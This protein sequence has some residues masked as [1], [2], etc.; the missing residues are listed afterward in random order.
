[1]MQAGNTGWHHGRTWTNTEHTKAP[2]LVGQVAN[3]ETPGL[4]SQDANG[5]AGTGVSRDVDRNALAGVGR[6][7]DWKTLA[8]AGE[9]RQSSGSK[10][11]PRM[12]NTKSKD[13][14]NE[15]RDGVASLEDM[16][17]NVMN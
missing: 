1:M 6:A 13:K 9:K 11:A 8:A 7:T 16:D 5:G 17:E 14:S 12:C 2:G 4:V 10:A 15:N 3:K